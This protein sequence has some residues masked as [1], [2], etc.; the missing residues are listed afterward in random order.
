M[1]DFLNT[2]QSTITKLEKQI[3]DKDNNISSN[4]LINLKESASIMGARRIVEVIELI[5]D[6]SAQNKPSGYKLYYWKM[7]LKEMGYF[8]NVLKQSGIPAGK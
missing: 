3:Q 1:L 4:E 2:L 7:L 5:D 6:N 8:H